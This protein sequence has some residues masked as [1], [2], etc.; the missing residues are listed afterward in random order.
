MNTSVPSKIYETN[1]PDIQAMCLEIISGLWSVLKTKLIKRN[2]LINPAAP[3]EGTRLF[4]LFRFFLHGTNMVPFIKHQF[5]PTIYFPYTLSSDFDCELVINPSLNEK[6]YEDAHRELLDVVF[7]YLIAAVQDPKYWHLVTSS[8]SLSIDYPI[9]LTGDIYTRY[10]KISAN[11][12][13]YNTIPKES[14]FY[15]YKVNELYVGDSG[16]S[17][18]SQVK[19]GIR[20]PSLQKGYP[21]KMID[22]I[23][24]SILKQENPHTTH[25][26][27]ITNT[28]LGLYKEDI[29]LRGRPIS[30]EFPRLTIP[31]AI[32]NL[33]YAAN[34]THEPREGKREKRMALARNLAKFKKP[35]PP[36]QAKSTVGGNRRTRRRK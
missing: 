10:N 30:V 20:I 25:L 26:W 5:D 28:G 22:L 16:P 33:E 18:I 23:D 17:N 15:V 27:D 13:K 7:L 21:Y 19:F 32:R 11:K 36:R 35:H 3:L 4:E 34:A 14:P 12:G 9:G 8:A 1:L 2:V 6:L 31:S 29:K 24:V